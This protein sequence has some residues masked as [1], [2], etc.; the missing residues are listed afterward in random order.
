M[1]FTFGLRQ[2]STGLGW[3][4]LF[5]TEQKDLDIARRRACLLLGLGREVVGTDERATRGSEICIH[6]SR[7]VDCRCG[8]KLNESFIS[9]KRGLL[10]LYMLLCYTD[11]HMDALL[12][13]SR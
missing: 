2:S 8:S 10:R 6:L 13:C 1:F 7:D 5:S 12:F 11:T 3:D 4:L 9:F